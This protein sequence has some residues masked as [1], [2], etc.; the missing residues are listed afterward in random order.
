MKQDNV[1]DLY[2]KIAKKY[3]KNRSLAS[4]DVTEFP[5]VIELIGNIKGKQILDLGCGI[6]KHS[7]EYI[8]KG[9]Q[10]TGID[11]SEEMIKITKNVCEDKGDFFVANFEEVKFDK[12]SFDLIV[13]SFSIHYS[14]KLDYLFKQFHSWLKPNGRV[15]FSIYHQIQYF[16]K[17]YKF[18]FS[19]SKK[20]WFRLNSY[21]VD[22][23][24]YYH[25]I[26]K[27][28]E[29][30]LSNGFQLKSINETTVPKDLKC[31]SDEEKRIPNAIIF[32]IVNTKTSSVLKHEILPSPLF[33]ITHTNKLI[34]Y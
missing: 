9:A 25:P 7:K 33:H 6:G 15:I 24:N 8:K 12:E 3:N 11:A 10:V 22:I 18:D 29:S 5:K 26:G 30:F 2:N 4:N 16:L 17:T 14:N 21:D 32:A 28:C 23:Y 20:Y 27:Y 34:Y 31:W 13:A 19:K 1:K